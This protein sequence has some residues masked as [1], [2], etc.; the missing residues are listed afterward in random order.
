MTSTIPEAAK[1]AQSGAIGE[2]DSRIRFEYWYLST[3]C[4]MNRRRVKRHE[5]TGQYMDMVVRI[6]WRAWRKGAEVPT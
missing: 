2:D 6:A 1:E 5:V 3:Q 4:A